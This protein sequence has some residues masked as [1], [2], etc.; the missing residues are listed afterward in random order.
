M[1]HLDRWC[2]QNLTLCKP[3]EEVVYS[4]EGYGEQKTQVE[5]ESRYA[6]EAH[7]EGYEVEGAMRERQNLQNSYGSCARMVD[8]RAEGVVHCDR[9]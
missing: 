8:E 1:Q 5:A 4:S 3:P 6:T 7:W 9:C 2:F